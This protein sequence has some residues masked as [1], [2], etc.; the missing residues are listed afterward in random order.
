MKTYWLHGRL[1]P[2]NTGHLQET[3]TLLEP[4]GTDLKIEPQKPELMQDP[5]DTRS[6]YSPVTFE[7]VSRYSPIMSPTSSTTSD[8]ISQT[9][10]ER[11]NS[12]RLPEPSVSP[13]LAG[14]RKGTIPRL[15]V[16][17]KFPV[18]LK[19][20]TALS[21][22]GVQTSPPLHCPWEITSQCLRHDRR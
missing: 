5:S 6:L 11:N 17:A 1:K 2:P 20:S 18:D 22:V 19:K 13:K 16:E 15:S 4:S 12:L 9:G 14:Y 8:I 7:D 21:T 3:P 10:T